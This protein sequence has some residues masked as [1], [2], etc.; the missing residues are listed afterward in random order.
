MIHRPLFQLGR[1]LTNLVWTEH[2]LTSQR[3][4]SNEQRAYPDYSISTFSSGG[5]TIWLQTTRISKSE[6]Q[7]LHGLTMIRIKDQL[8]FIPFLMTC[9]F[10]SNVSPVK[11]TY[12]IG[13]SIH[14]SWSFISVIF[15]CSTCAISNVNTL[16]ACLMK[17]RR[18]IG[19]CIL[20]EDKWSLH[21][22]L[23]LDD[24]KNLR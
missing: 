22:K 7:H 5:G 20:F 19:S 10:Y 18:I 17:K 12:F 15:S 11:S 14:I 23:V 6:L 2:A 24:S 1:F 9:W 8:V 16:H 13:T 4:T 21:A 3:A